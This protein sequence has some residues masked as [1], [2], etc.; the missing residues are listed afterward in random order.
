MQS[1]NRT[2]DITVTKNGVKHLFLRDLSVPV[3]RGLLIQIRESV[4][5]G[6]YNLVYQKNNLQYSSQ[7]L[8]IIVKYEIILK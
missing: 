3:A 8:G 7:E 1:K 5:D 4:D 2:C 6:R